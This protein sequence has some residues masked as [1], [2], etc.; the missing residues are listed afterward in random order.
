M[1]LTCTCTMPECGKG[2][3]RKWYLG[4]PV[5]LCGATGDCCKPAARTAFALRPASDVQQCLCGII[6]HGSHAL[7]VTLPEGGSSA[8][9]VSPRHSY[10]GS[11]PP[12]GGASADTRLAVTQPAAA[13][14]KT[15][16]GREQRKPT[17]E[18]C[19]STTKR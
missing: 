16:T 2:V 1:G 10:T 7:C 4:T 11:F 13:G 12:V 14:I 19:S 8:W 17:G 5:A 9:G 3:F 15:D 18:Y 6:S